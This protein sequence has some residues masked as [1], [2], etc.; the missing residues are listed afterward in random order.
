MKTMRTGKPHNAITT[1]AILLAA[2]GCQTAPKIQT[3]GKTAA[4][5]SG[6]RIER[7]RTSVAASSDDTDLSRCLVR[8]TL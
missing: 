3:K 2:A 6:Y 8:W 1:A 5:F 7:G 4:D